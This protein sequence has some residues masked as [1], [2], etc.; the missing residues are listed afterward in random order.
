MADG[1]DE[2]IAVR[3]STVIRVLVVILVLAALGIGILIGSHRSTAHSAVS[4]VRAST[5]TAAP[6]ASTSTTPS[7]STTAPSVTTTTN[8]ARQILAPATTPPVVDECSEPLTYG[9]DG[10]TSTTCPGGGGVNVLAWKYLASS[11][12]VLLGL[13]A[14]AT[15]QQAT[16]AMCESSPP[17]SQ[18]QEAAAMAATYYGWPFAT[19]PTFTGWNA[20]DCSG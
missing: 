16:Q 19:V 17:Y 12:P 5:T 11:Y 2:T 6:P 10:G 14:N 1:H 15:E 8:P 4:T 3:K 18:V 13:G 9:A 7:A 20:S